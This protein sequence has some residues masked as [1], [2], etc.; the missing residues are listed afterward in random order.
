MEIADLPLR[1]R[2][3]DGLKLWWFRLCANRVSGVVI[4]SMKFKESLKLDE[5]FVF[6]NFPNRDIRL[7]LYDLAKERKK[8]DESAEYHVFYGRLR[9]LDVLDAFVCGA[10]L[11]QLKIYGRPLE[12]LLH[13]RGIGAT[14]LRESYVS[15][16]QYEQDIGD[17][18]KDAASI[19]A[20]YDTKQENARL[21]IPNKLFDAV[22]AEIPFTCSPETY[23]N[24]RAIEFGVSQKNFEPLFSSLE[25]ESMFQS[26]ERRF[27][28]F[29]K[30]KI[31]S[32]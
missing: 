28:I 6:E 23:V 20:I 10:G 7:K 2:P 3:L 12:R 22:C 13:Y 26:I 29:I 32:F 1:G 17:I 30:S 11:S 24:Q 27:I 8:S 18:L 21:A 31:D 4:T 16:F 14:Q 25:L 15:E 9:Y 5:A 19:L